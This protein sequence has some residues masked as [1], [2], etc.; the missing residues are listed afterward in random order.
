[1]E[2][3]KARKRGGSSSQ[4]GISRE[5][6]CVLVARDRQKMTY[7]KV[8]GQGR[9]VKT[10]LEEAIGSKLSPIDILCTDPGGHL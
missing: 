5:Q 4:R 3:R 10:R 2:G 1:M 8:V 6:V 9:I 7:S